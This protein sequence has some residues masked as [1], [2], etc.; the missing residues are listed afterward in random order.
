LILE[1]RNKR[2]LRTDV[3]VVLVRCGYA[4]LARIAKPPI[5]ATKIDM[6]YGK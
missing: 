5:F 4:A 3:A 2:R 6:A 1:F